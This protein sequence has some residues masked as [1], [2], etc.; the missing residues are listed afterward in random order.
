MIL[1]DFC[2]ASE[3]R[4]L[5]KWKWEKVGGDCSQSLFWFLSCRL[6]SSSLEAGLLPLP[7]VAHLDYLALDNE[8]WRSSSRAQALIGLTALMLIS[9]LPFSDGT[10]D[11]VFVSHLQTITHTPSILILHLLWHRGLARPF[12]PAFD[13][14]C[15]YVN[16][17]RF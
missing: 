17:T 16:F 1:D 7:L 8:M 12:V 15:R 5:E 4:L 9:A 10:F 3:L 13:R 2:S 14:I 11:L 6:L